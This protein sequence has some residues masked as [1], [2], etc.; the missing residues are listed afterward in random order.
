M[1]AIL[2]VT[3][4]T[5]HLTI[6]GFSLHTPSVLIAKSAG[7]KTYRYRHYHAPSDTPDKLAYPELTRI[8]AGLFAAFAEL[9]R[10]GID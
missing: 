4:P 2:G 1:S 7:S 9:A 5:T 8:T 10:R 3:N 6:S